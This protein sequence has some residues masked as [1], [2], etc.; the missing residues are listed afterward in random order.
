MPVAMVAPALMLALVLV[1]VLV[2]VL[3]PV[4]V[5]VLRQKPRATIVQILLGMALT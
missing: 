2:L 4:L 1:L 5:L 3:G